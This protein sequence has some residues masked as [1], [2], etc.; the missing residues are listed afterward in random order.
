MDEILAQMPSEIFDTD[1]YQS[2]V[3]LRDMSEYIEDTC[4]TSDHGQV[5]TVILTIGKTT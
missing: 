3:E 5:R 2:Y 4:L 1:L